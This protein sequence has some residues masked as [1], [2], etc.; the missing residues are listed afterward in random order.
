MPVHMTARFEI[1]PESAA[2]VQKAV[3]DFVGAIQANE[4]HTVLYRSMREVDNPAAYLHYFVFKDSDAEEFHRTTAWVNR[5]VEILY[6]ETIHE[7]TFTKYEEVAS[8]GAA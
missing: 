5:F 8:T 7:V 2:I 4:P 6:P 3:E 1:K